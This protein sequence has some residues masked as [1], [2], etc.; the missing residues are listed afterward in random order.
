MK[1]VLMAVAVH[2][3]EDSGRTALTDRTLQSL[4]NTVD[5]NRH[6]LYI[7]DNASCEATHAI[8]KKFAKE[9]TQKFNPSNLTIIWN[10]ENLGTAKAINKAWIH[11]Q[12]GQHCI[13]MDND[14]EYHQSGWVDLMVECAE[15]EPKLGI[16]GL[17]RKDCWEHAL[18]SDGTEH[19]DPSLRSKLFML[20]HQ[21]GEKWLIVEA[22]NHVMGTC[23]L[24]TS[25][26]LDKIGYLYQPSLYGWD[27][28]LAAQRSHLAGFWNVFIPSVEIDHIDPGGTLYQN[29]KERH[30]GEAIK[31]LH[32]VQTGYANGTRPIYE[33]P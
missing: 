2:E 13:K 24:Y 27:D 1:E 11:R 19:K 9:F 18:M 5:F 7:I 15:R 8:F 17:K 21:P 25:A 22:V 12:P 30:A 20:P 4:L 16:I 23:Q 6:K 14:V 3:L 32:E 31:E 28:V 10:E 26:L 29:W 33:Q